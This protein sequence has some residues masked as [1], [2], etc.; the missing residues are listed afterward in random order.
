MIVACAYAS[1][2]DPSDLSLAITGT[3]VID[4]SVASSRRTFR[5]MD[6]GNDAGVFGLRK[7]ICRN[8][9]PRQHLFAGS[10][11]SGSNNT[12]FIDLYD[13]L[14]PTVCIRRFSRRPTWDG[15]VIMTR[16]NP[17]LRT[18]YG[19]PFGGRT[20]RIRLIDIHIT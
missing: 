6:A 17:D 4:V 5:F 10:G 9:S 16:G 3:V 15:A 12:D 8:P 13:A 19:I 2:R 1:M 11:I 20:S 7:L 14:A 18:W